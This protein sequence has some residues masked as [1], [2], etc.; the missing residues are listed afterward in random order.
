MRA[1]LDPELLG[2]T[3]QDL[4]RMKQGEAMSAIVHL[5]VRLGLFDALNAAPESTSV[6]LADATGLHE[7]WIREWLCAVAAAGLAEHAD[8]RFNLTPEASATL[9]EPDHP[10]ATAGVFGL[11]ITH[12]EINRTAEAFETGLGMTWSEH[13]VHACHF[14]AAMSA[15]GQRAWLVPVILDSIEGMTERLTAGA[16][17]VDVGC[18]SGVA[19]AA[20]AGAYPQST[21][22]GIDPSAHAIESANQRAAAEGL[23]NL[24][25]RSGAFDDLVNLS[26]VD[27]LVTLDVLHDLPNPQAAVLAAK[28]CLA[29]DGVWMVADIKTRGGLEENRAIPVLPL[30]YAM[31]ILYCMS[32]A[33]SEPD[34]AGLGTL[35]LTVEVFEQLAFEAGFGS[36]DA[37]EF[38]ID[39][40][41]RYYEVRI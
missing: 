34:G 31:S 6:E 5:G 20:I 39:P 28:S 41:N 30:M 38:E 32:S 10:A 37:R 27:L 9:C 36:V 33:M 19:A 24:S 12:H 13:G 35:G 3:I 2:Q 22:L 25:F 26:A 18:G 14:Q 11:P 17:V 7:R 40:L 4:Y 1:E 16:T 15:S 21:V 8:G 23:G 29:D